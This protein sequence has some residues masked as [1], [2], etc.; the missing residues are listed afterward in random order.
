MTTQVEQQGPAILPPPGTQRTTFNRFARRNGLQLGIIGVFVLIWIVLIIGAPRT[1]LSPNIYTALM[2][3]I[4]FFGIVALPLTMV[5]VAREIDLSF[6]SI[7]AI[8]MVGYVLVYNPTQSILLGVLAALVVGTLAGLLNGL[9]VVGLGIPSLITTIGTM[10]LWRGAVLIISNGQGA[11]LTPVKTTLLRDLLV[12]RIGSFLPIQILW[13]IG[14]G[15]F[16]W[17]LQNRHRFGA[18]IYLIGDNENSAR[19]MGVNA[20]RTRILMFALVGL[21]SALCGV[22]ASLDVSYFWPATLGDGYLMPTLAAVFLGGTSVFGGKGTVLG[23]FIGCL[24]I[25]IIDP[26]TV[27]IGLTGYWTQFIYGFII[28]MSVAMHT[29][30]RRRVS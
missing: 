29:I 13:M 2:E 26:G 15:I 11:S 28:V 18:H 25:A 21:A 6:G 17:F 27:A 16:I 14:I 24:I 8:S 22:M 20:N 23:T 3:S 19:L 10:F 1:F 7:M 12:G 4:P 30:L 5:V 9:I